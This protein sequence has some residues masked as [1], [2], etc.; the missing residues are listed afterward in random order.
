MFPMRQIGLILTGVCVALLFL[1]LTGCNVDPLYPKARRPKGPAMSM[2]E[3]PGG[4][5]APGAE[6]RVVDRSEVDLVE[7]VVTHRAAYL[8][9]LQAL[10]DYY[11]DHGYVNK[12][13]WA[14]FELFGL[15]KVQTFRYVMDAEIPSDQL[16]PT[17]TIPEADALYKRGMKLMANGGHGIPIFYREGPMIEAVAVFRQLIEKY[18]T[19]DKIDDAAFQLGEIHKEY[20]H[21]QESIAVKWYERAWTWDPATPHSARFQAA[22]I[23]DFRLHDRDRALELYQRV[24][25]EE[26]SDWTNV[27]FS[28]H[29]IGE[30]TREGRTAR[31]GT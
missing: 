27:C 22:V 4:G 5:G 6:I 25:R 9:S 3:R 30:L 12:Q 11:R 24:L 14:D 7:T 28:K 23:Y 26:T 21:D 31:A 19:S 13:S 1:A 8:Q 17:D 2:A 15:Q 18:P 10:R 20:L 29:R 16:R